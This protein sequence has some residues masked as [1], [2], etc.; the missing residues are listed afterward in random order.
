MLLALGVWMGYMVASCVAGLL[1]AM[2]VGRLTGNTFSVTYMPNV[3]FDLGL[4]ILFAATVVAAAPFVSKLCKRFK[5]NSVETHWGAILLFILLNGAFAFLLH[6]G[7]YLFLWPALFMTSLLVIKLLCPAHRRRG[8]GFI[9][10]IQTFA[11]IVT[12]ILYTTLLYSLFLALTFGSLTIILLFVSLLGC[13]LMT[14]LCV[15]G[16]P[17][18]VLHT[19]T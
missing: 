9:L 6:G 16:K 4:T 17:A 15:V 14:M 19:S 2:L 1:L 8:A 12:L 10:C 7:T 3:P 5:C 18:T 13:A 11:V